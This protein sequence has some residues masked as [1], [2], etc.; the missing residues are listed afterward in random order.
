MPGNDA[1]NVVARAKEFLQTHEVDE[2]DRAELEA[3][4]ASEAMTELEDRFSGLP[5]FGTAGIRG[6]M[7]AGES[8]MNRSLV[9][10]VTHGVVRYLLDTVPDAAT[11]GIAIARDGRHRSDVFQ[12]DAAA[13]AAALGM[14]VHF[15]GGTSPTPLLAFAV[16][17]LGAAAGIVITASHNPPEYNGYKVY[18]E[19]GAQIIPPIDT[20]IAEAV[21]SSPGARAIARDEGSSR[22]EEVMGMADAYV[23][24]V[25]AL[26]MT[27][28]AD[29]APLRV[30]YSALHG[31]GQEIFSKVMERRGFER[32]FPVPEQALPD[33]DFPTV[34]FPNPEEPGA[35]DLVL[36][37]ATENSCPLVVVNDPDAD[38]L[39]A[40][41]R[42]AIGSYVAL[43]GNEIGVLL[44]HHILTNT[45]VEK[46]LVVSTVVSSRMLSKMAS[47]L[48]ARYEDTLT[49]FKWIT[50]EAMRIEAEEGCTFVFGYEE[51]LGYTVGTVVRDKDGISAG[52]LLAE[53]AAGLDAR[54]ETL[55]DEL[56]RLRER[57]G[58]YVSRQKSVTLA[59][60]EGAA[61]IRDAMARLH[62]DARDTIVSE[63]V[64]RQVRDDVLIYDLADGGRAAVRPSGTEPK[65]KF[66]LE[67]VG[68]DAESRLD[69]FETELMRAAGLA[70]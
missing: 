58:H 30:A 53:L 20:G 52:V 22:I 50:N 12:R 5:T 44:A 2:D 61:K 28:D 42:T 3:L 62:R 24:A 56:A 29:V 19:N 21:E 17:Y 38:R 8:R 14:R 68:D 4:I 54:G 41:V 66:Y 70:G 35:L 69:A 7:G 48:G 25:S 37:V 18:W 45:H 32:I 67:V 55:L 23:E 47:E 6:V 27:P 43:N 26:V 9:I 1:A 10:R 16:R 49:G 57:Y 40:A 51:A 36:E 33:G 31:V 65:L 59:G 63:P 60:A 39:G 13:V 46:P 11:R 34:Q 15:L 64:T